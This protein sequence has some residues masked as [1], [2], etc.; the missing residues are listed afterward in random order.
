M[1]LWEI[2]LLAYAILVTWF[3]INGVVKVLLEEALGVRDFNYKHPEIKEGEIFLTNIVGLRLDLEPYLSDFLAI[4]WKT[5][6]LGMTAYD[7]YGNSLD[8]MYPCFV[9]RAELLK[10]GINVAKMEQENKYV[11]LSRYA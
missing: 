2:V 11:K 1:K 7:I 8:G 10:A 3:F 5:K 4:G 9:Q 6:R